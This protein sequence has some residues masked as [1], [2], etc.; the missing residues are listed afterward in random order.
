MQNLFFSLFIGL[1]SMEVQNNS[2]KRTAILTNS[3][4]LSFTCMLSREWTSRSTM[5]CNAR[6]IMLFIGASLN[7]PHI[8]HDNGLCVRNNGMYLSIYLYLRTYPMFVAP[9]FPRSVYALKC[10]VY[11]CIPPYID[12][13]TCVI[14]FF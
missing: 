14:F 9:W 8:D 3:D 7:E 2:K 10:S 4:M 5:H 12:V 11:S 6:S 13:L 1:Y